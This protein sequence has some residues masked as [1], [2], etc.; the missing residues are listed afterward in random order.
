M[1][2]AI[3]PVKRETFSTIRERGKTRPLLVE[4]HSTYLTIRPKGRR[5]SY[6]VTYDQ[7]WMIGARNAA[8]ATRKARVEARK[9]KK[10]N[11]ST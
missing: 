1:T 11:A 7:V 8:E 2:K 3:K 6:A 4:L 9:K 5:Y 10:E